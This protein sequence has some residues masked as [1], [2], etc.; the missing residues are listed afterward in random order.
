MLSNIDW[1]NL[2]WQARQM[3]TLFAADT[4][5]LGRTFSQALEAS[6]PQWNDQRYAPHYVTVRAASHRRPRR[7]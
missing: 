2:Y 3:W 5:R 1:S 6:R 4:L 7:Y